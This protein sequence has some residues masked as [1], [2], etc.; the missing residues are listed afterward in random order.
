M[1]SKTFAAAT[2]A[3]LVAVALGVGGDVV[4]QPS[5]GS[6]HGCPGMM[7]PGM[8]GPGM[9]GPGMMGGPGTMGPGIMGGGSG[10]YQY[11]TN[12]TVAD[13][14][15]YLE[16]W[17]AAMGNPRLKVGAVKEKDANTIVGEIVT[18]DGSV[19]QRFEVDRNTGVYRPA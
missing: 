13:V 16:Q 4:A 6:W 15:T 2:T 9:M 10:Y 5:Q 17:V 8:M 14:K 18:Q 3:V 19:V 11:P 7:G 1:K 12:P